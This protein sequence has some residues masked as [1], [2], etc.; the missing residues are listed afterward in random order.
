[1]HCAHG[2]AVGARRAQCAVRSTCS[3][4]YP[5]V[6][7]YTPIPEEFTEQLLCAWL[8]PGEAAKNLTDKVPSPASLHPSGGD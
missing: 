6:P 1:M 4:L 7:F 5:H 2:R 3:V 8:C